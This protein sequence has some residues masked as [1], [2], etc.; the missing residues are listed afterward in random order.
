M[1]V[2]AIND[3]SCVGKCSLTVALPVISACGVTCDVLPTALLSTHTG[4][5]DGYAFHDL[6]GEIGKITA[7][8]KKLGLRFDFIYSGYLG[9]VEQIDAVARIRDEFLSADGKFIVD[10]V[11]GDSGK[12]YDRFDG[13]FVAKMRELCKRADYILPNLTEACFLTDTPYP[14][15]QVA[16]G[17]ALIEKLLKINPCPVITGV[18]EENELSVFYVKDGKSE[19]IS[20]CLYEGFFVGAGDLFASAFVGCLARQ[21]SLS[22]AVCLAMHFTTAAIKR[23]AKEVPDKRFGLN[24]EKE[25]FAF[26]QALNGEEHV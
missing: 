4:G 16:D 22:E 20:S 14:V 23:S 10:P 13:H 15:G 2:L 26:L 1:R 7:H 17:S 5:F 18:H 24:F 25:I 21:K 9:S 12:L 8:W 19:R 6:T 11:M 3:V